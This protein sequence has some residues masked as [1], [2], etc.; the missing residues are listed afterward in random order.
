VA[1]LAL[2]HSCRVRVVRRKLDLLLFFL[3]LPHVCHEATAAAVVAV[4][5]RAVDDL[6]LGDRTNFAAKG[7]N[8][9]LEYGVGGEGVAR[10]TSALVLD[11]S[12]MFSV[13]HTRS[14]LPSSTPFAAA[15]GARRATSC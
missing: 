4:T 1:N 14:K 8:G 2:A 5:T 10:A 13:V 15:R 7:I 6:L 12:H 3:V 11:F 9:S